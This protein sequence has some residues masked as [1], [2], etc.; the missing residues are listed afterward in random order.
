MASGYCLAPRYDWP[1]LDPKHVLARVLL[2]GFLHDRDRLRVIAC[3]AGS[4]CLLQH[5]VEGLDFFVLADDILRLNVRL[6]ALTV[7]GQIENQRIAFP[8]GNRI[9]GNRLDGL[10]VH[11]ESGVI[12][13][14]RGPPRRKTRPEGWWWP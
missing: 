11:Q 10:P 4:R 7:P 12:T 14:L 8:A 1:R 5:L 6:A 9:A 13:C 2:R 3:L